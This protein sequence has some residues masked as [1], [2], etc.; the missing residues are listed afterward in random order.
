MDKAAVVRLSLEVSRHVS[1]ESC[2]AG[3]AHSG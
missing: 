2:Y 1:Q 3:R